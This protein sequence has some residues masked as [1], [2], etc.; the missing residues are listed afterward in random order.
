MSH[1]DGGHYRFNIIARRHFDET[2]KVAGLPLSVVSQIVDELI[3]E[4]GS[5]LNATRTLLDKGISSQLFESIAQGML[6]RL[7]IL[8]LD[9]VK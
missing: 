2:A 6:T 5:A 8:K 7:E 4:V 3:V 9:F 1:A